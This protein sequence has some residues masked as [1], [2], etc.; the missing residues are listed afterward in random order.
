MSSAAYSRDFTKFRIAVIIS[1]A[2][3]LLLFLTAVVSPKWLKSSKKGMTHYVN[4]VA[5]SGGGGGQGGSP[6]G[7]GGGG[8]RS[9]S[10]RKETVTETSVPQR[11]SLK[12]L[13]IPERAVREPSETAMRHPDKQSER[14]KTVTKPGKKT[15]IQK[16]LPSSTSGSSSSSASP[17]GSGLGI[18]LG[19]GTGGGTGF[20]SAYD[21]QAGLTHFPFRYYLQ[22]V[23]DKV[24]S[25][26]FKSP[27]DPGVSENLKTTVYFRILRNGNISNLRITERS[28][29][30]SLD[31]KALRAV[32]DS[33]PFPPL[34]AEYEG[35]YLGLHLYFEHSK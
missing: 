34:P 23:T 28:G 4:L 35:D 11:E 8:L 16:S 7:G 5:M 19:D 30:R 22:Y 31:M 13:T 32:Q 10:Q 15:S 20:G 18:G 33:V 1:F 24:S 27:F 2:A 25:H 17:P 14:K 3:H 26:W 29:L 12:D 21:L 9:A 6:G